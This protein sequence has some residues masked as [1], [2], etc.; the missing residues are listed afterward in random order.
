LMK[1]GMLSCRGISRHLIL[2]EKTFFDICYLQGHT[3][4]LY[5][6]KIT[7]VSYTFCVVKLKLSSECS[8]ILWFT[9]C[10]DPLIVENSI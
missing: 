5:S 6:L 8:I 1:Y 3:D 7:N 10:C 2:C 4:P 9:V